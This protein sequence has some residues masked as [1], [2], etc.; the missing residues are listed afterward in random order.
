MR[1]SLG[2]PE[3]FRTTYPLIWPVYADYTAEEWNSGALDEYA[4]QA[5]LAADDVFMINPVSS[6][7]VNHGGS[8]HFHKGRT[9]AKIP[10]DQEGVLIAEI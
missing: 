5:A 10:F 4:A 3:K 2:L 6:D 1:R 8:F 7:P 9:A